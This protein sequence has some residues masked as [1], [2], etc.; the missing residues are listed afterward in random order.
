MPREPRFRRL[1]G[2]EVGCFLRRFLQFRQ[3]V[4]GVGRAR[5]HHARRAWPGEKTD[6]AGVHLQG[7]KWSAGLQQDLR[8]LR[9]ALC[10]NDS[11]KAQRE[12]KLARG[13]PAN[14]GAGR[15]ATQVGLGLVNLILHGVG[16]KQGHEQA[17]AWRALSGG[18]GIRDGVR[19][20]VRHG[21][22]AGACTILRA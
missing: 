21:L 2:E 7:R 9:H 14:C 6:A 11:E 4:R 1:I 13:S 8:K 16:Q 12:M 10:G 20:R 15:S 19:A 22:P 5:P 17:P 3:T 18:R